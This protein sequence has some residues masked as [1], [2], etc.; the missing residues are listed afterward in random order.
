MSYTDYIDEHGYMKL[1]TDEP[2]QINNGILFLATYV[3]LVAATTGD[4]DKV[5]ELEPTVNKALKFFYENPEIN[6]YSHDN[7]TAY[8][9]LLHQYGYDLQLTKEMKRRYFRHP[10]DIIFYGLIKR[11]WWVIPFVPLFYIMAFLS[12]KKK[13][14][15]RGDQKFIHT[16]G[17]ILYILRGSYGFD[18]PKFLTM[19]FTIIAATLETETPVHECMRIYYKDIHHPN[20][21]ISQ[22]VI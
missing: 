22:G 20:R 15:V 10:R 5:N 18:S 6:N 8:L 9:C 3:T 16:D 7:I 17:K 21:R 19:V 11:A 12:C 14:K 13:Y 4:I 1:T 2:E